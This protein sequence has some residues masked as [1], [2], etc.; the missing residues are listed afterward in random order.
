MRERHWNQL[1]EQLGTTLNPGK[2]FTLVKAEE[3]KLLDHLEA[4][5]K[6]ADVA[7]KEFSIEQVRKFAPLAVVAVVASIPL[8]LYLVDLMMLTAS[9][10]SP[11]LGQDAARVGGR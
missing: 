2:D 5:T 4:I 11:G 1:S 7:G 3:M 8:Y 10:H 6:V 9:I